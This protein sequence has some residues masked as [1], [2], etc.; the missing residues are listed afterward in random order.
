MTDHPTSVA[1]PPSGRYRIDPGASSIGFSAKHLFWLLTVHGRIP[2]SSG[3][4]TIIDEIHRSTSEVRAD[5]TAF[6]TGDARRDRAVKG[7][8]FLDVERHPI[9]AFA[10]NGVVTDRGAWTLNGVLTVREVA[11]P[12]T[13]SVTDVSS[14][15]TGVTIRATG[16]IDRYAHGVTATKGLTG[17]FLELELEVHAQPFTTAHDPEI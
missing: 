7:P 3:E 10:S 13:L 1:P 17:R 16:R 14:D 5:A 15:A 9:F 12:L 6:A 2:I 8:R 11:A 4:F